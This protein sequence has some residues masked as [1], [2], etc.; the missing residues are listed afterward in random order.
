MKH[1]SNLNLKKL[2]KQEGFSLM[3]ALLVSAV[4]L[5]IS[6]AISAL[7][8]AEIR[9]VG[10]YD[11]SVVAYYAADAGIEDSLLTLNKTQTLSSYSHPAPPPNFIVDASSSEGVL[12]GPLSQD[13]TVEVA[14]SDND[15]PD[16]VE[17][18]WEDKGTDA[19]T[20]PASLEWTLI[21]YTKNP[22][23]NYPDK[24]DKGFYDSTKPDGLRY[25]KSTYSTQSIQNGPN[26]ITISNIGYSIPGGIPGQNVYF[27]LRVKCLAQAEDTPQPF[28]EGQ[29][30]ITYKIT[31]KN[32]ELTSGGYLIG[33]TGES[34]TVR[35]KIE[36][37]TDAFNQGVFGIFD[38]VLYTEDTLYKPY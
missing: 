14:S 8:I 38:Y 5:V 33:S 21:P 11:D 32:G 18:T 29:Y 4:V 20:K 17:I 10:A 28:I 27:K 13:E 36:V 1:N 12:D 35:R 6:L 22:I 7:I 30:K 34:N 26:K 37:R 31:P 3:I 2:K 19:T 9:L 23:K 25:D 15:P 24:I 16:I